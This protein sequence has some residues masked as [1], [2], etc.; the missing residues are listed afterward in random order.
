M[1]IS[2]YIQSGLIETY[3]LGLANEEEIAELDTL[4]KQYVDIEVAIN[5]FSHDLEQQAFA[6]AV[7]APDHLKERLMATIRQD[8]ISAPVVSFSASQNETQIGVH[9]INIDSRPW[10]MMAAASVLLFAVSAALNFYFYNRYAEKN[11]AYQALLTERNTLTTSNQVYQTS[12][13]EWEHTARMMSDPA[14][15]KIKM[16]SVG[17]K[18]NK[19]ATIFWDSRNRDVYV[20]AKELPQPEAGKQFQ[21]WAIVDGKPVDAGMI[22]PDCAG[23]CKMKNIPKAKAFAITLEKEGGSP[24]PHLDQL[25]V[26]GNT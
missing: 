3:V 25:V 22:S 4:R 9:R 17:G 8:N 5:T 18:N 26:M 2:A 10:K 16:K 15:L 14:M 11:E 7:P 19:D 13:K 6:E 21:L 24:T 12:Q 23:V 20:M 1:N